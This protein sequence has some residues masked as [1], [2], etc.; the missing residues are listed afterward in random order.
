MSAVAATVQPANSEVVAG[1]META[2]SK[3]G[4]AIAYDRI[5]EGPALILIAGALCSRTSWSGPVLARLLAP[6]VTVYNYDR[7]G[8]GESGDTQPYAV[9]REIEDIEA[10][11]DAAGGAASLY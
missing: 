4:T 3:D 1:A 8:R 7:R 6:R 10:L 11:I 5:G 9:E 2:T